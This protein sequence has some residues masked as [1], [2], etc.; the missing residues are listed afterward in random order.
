M[1]EQSGFVFGPE[2]SNVVIAGNDIIV[3]IT[4]LFSN[5]IIY[6][7]FGHPYESEVHITEN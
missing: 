7:Q 5:Y 1:A 3:Y 6:R 4:V 2:R